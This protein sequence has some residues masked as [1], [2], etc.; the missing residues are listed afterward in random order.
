MVKIKAVVL[1]LGALAA[2]LAAFLLFFESEE[3]RIKKQFRELA[4]MISRESGEN[5]LQAAANARKIARMLADPCTVNIPTY[6]ITRTV[7]RENAQSYI[8]AGRSR[9]SGLSVAFHDLAVTFPE[10]G[11]AAVNLTVYAETRTGNG[12]P[13]NNIFEAHCELE[14]TEDA[15][16][17]THFA[18]VAVLEK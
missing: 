5:H 10:K 3:A 11:R 16:Y 14:K 17:L 15:W 18:E 7:S 6:E 2:G 4:A 13:E 8:M 9:Y 1:V 12:P